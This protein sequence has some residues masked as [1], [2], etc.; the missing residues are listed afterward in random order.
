MHP[1]AVGLILLSAVGH[2]YWNYQ[3]KRSPEPAIYAWCMLM[4]SA[5]LFAPVAIRWAWPLSVP[6]AGWACVAATALFY[7]GYFSFIALSYRREDLSRAYPIARGVAPVA[8]AAWGVLFHHDHVAPN[9]R[10]A[11]GA[12]RVGVAG[13]H[14]RPRSGLA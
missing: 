8:T 1:A 4:G 5:L 2:V 3:V 14:K 10:V 12:D 13:D 7:G 11:R 6:A 9:R